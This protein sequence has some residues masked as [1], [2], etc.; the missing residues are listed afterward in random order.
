[1]NIQTK[2]AVIL[3]LFLTIFPPSLYATND[4]T[5]HFGFSAVAGYLAETT[6]HKQ[7]NS[8]NK[9]IVYSTALGTVP[10]LIKEMIDSNEEGNEFSGDDML[11]NIAGAFTG[12]FIASKVNNQL[13][14]TLQKH[15]DGYSVALLYRY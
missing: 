4:K 7:L 9:R 13:F 15:E 11:A 3:S 1:M 14:T 5:L 10:G 12:A 2:K 8:E 6:L